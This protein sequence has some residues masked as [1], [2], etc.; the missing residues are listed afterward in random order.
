MTISIGKPS[1][2]SESDHQ[3]FLFI[4]QQCTS[5]STSPISSYIA[6]GQKLKSFILKLFP[7]INPIH[8]ATLWDDIDRSNCCH[9]NYAQ[10]CFL[11]QQLV[12]LREG[13]MG[14]RI[15]WSLLTP[16]M[17][18][19]LEES[20]D[21][22]V[23]ECI[24]EFMIPF[25]KQ[26]CISSVVLEEFD[27]N[28]SALCEN[29][30]FTYSIKQAILIL[31]TA[32][33]KYT[34]TAVKTNSVQKRDG[35]PMSAYLESVVLCKVLFTVKSL[36]NHHI[37]QMKEKNESLSQVIMELEMDLKIPHI[38]TPYKEC[39]L[40]NN[41]KKELE[42]IRK[43][44]SVKELSFKF[45][46]VNISATDSAISSIRSHDLHNPFY[47]ADES[48]TTR[49]ST[50]TRSTFTKDDDSISHSLNSA[51]T[52]SNTKAVSGKS[53]STITYAKA[54]FAYV[55]QQDDEISM[56]KDCIIAVH[57]KKD[58]DWWKGEVVSTRIVGFFPSNYVTEMIQ[59]VATKNYSNQIVTGRAVYA[60]EHD[61]EWLL[62]YVPECD[63]SG[64]V[65]T[66]ILNYPKTTSSPPSASAASRNDQ[67]HSVLLELI[68]TENRYIQNLSLMVQF[69]YKPLKSSWSE[70]EV[71]LLFCNVCDILESSIS[72]S[73]ELSLCENGMMVSKL[74]LEHSF[75][76]YIKYC[77]NQSEAL[78][79]LIKRS[80][81]DSNFQHFLLQQKRHP[82]LKGM[83]L[84]AFLLEP[85]QRITR[86]P[87]LLK[88]LL[89]YTQNTLEQ[90]KLTQSLSKIE[91]LLMKINSLIQDKERDM[92]LRELNNKLI[93]DELYSKGCFSFD[94]SKNTKLMG[95][96]YLL[97]D[98]VVKK[99]RGLSK[100][101][102]LY[103]F[104]D[105]LL[106]VSIPKN[107][108]AS[109]SLL[110]DPIFTQNLTLRNDLEHTSSFVIDIANET[111]GKNLFFSINDRSISYLLRLMINFTLF[112]ILLPSY[113]H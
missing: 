84:G 74:F 107:S 60:L 82:D 73:N 106:F 12:G 55:K 48:S 59:C 67:Q 112:S 65:P 103:L 20:V 44:V 77:V 105:F 30:N 56:T 7:S 49:F 111:Q 11:M 50:A 43:L 95:R 3:N 85:M 5:P 14:K 22:E 54:N 47:E 101:C 78:E 41:R 31:Y 79:Y 4:F 68:N 36:L 34:L 27:G 94:L 1:F 86:Y 64:I 53:N 96:R 29:A 98:G 58:A 92:K 52:A 23:I 32:K 24:S 35:K 81:V 87:L 108:N 72:F 66:D 88:Q 93:V 2:V 19:E 57:D 104:N 69:Y 91:S 9:L 21:E 70:S 71:S 100:R 15:D 76:F 33:C 97:L 8:F 109:V 83:D 61:L 89:K 28:T 51:L 25:L 62:V 42:E 16:E 18:A 6:P 110:R 46:S 26:K 102:R 10:F 37:Q 90:Q 99:V 75:D 38:P 17:Q 40:K 45:H 63:W 39:N 80:K 113:F 13:K